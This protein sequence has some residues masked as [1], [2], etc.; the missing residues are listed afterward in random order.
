MPLLSVHQRSPCASCHDW[1][2]SIANGLK[3]VHQIG[4]PISHSG[5]SGQY[6]RPSILTLKPFTITVWASIFV[7]CFH[8]IPAAWT[9]KNRSIGNLSALVFPSFLVIVIPG[10]SLQSHVVGVGSDKPKAFPCVRHPEIGSSKSCPF[11]N[12]PTGG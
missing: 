10:V 12:I 8:F 7:V 11:A 9:H 4:H 1:N 2:L 3:S 6:S 5:K